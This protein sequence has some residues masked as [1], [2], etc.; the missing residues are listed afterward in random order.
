MYQRTC[1]KLTHGVR[2]F[3][4]INATFI[5]GLKISEAFFSIYEQ[6]LLNRIWFKHFL[7]NNDWSG[8]LGDILLF[9]TEIVKKY[10][11]LLILSLS[12]S[13]PMMDSS[14]FLSTSFILSW[15]NHLVP[16]HFETGTD[17][18]KILHKGMFCFGLLKMS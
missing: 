8:L 12:F 1:T 15:V 11:L 9:K 10:F 14:G 13:Q 18:L 3:L 2:V 4:D 5:K 6:I 7:K 16:S 17:E